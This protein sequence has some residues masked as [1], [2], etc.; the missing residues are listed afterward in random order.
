MI[1]LRSQTS[2]YE[3]AEITCFLLQKGKDKTAYINVFTAIELVPFE[4][5]AS[6]LVGSGPH[7]LNQRYTC[8]E[9]TLYLVRVIGLKVEE[10]VSIFESAEHGF[11]LERGYLKAKVI[12]AHLVRQEPSGN[13][14]LMIERWQKESLSAILPARP[15][16]FRVWTKIQLQKS[17]STP[18]QINSGA[19]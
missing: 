8:D 15:T 13:T 3:S 4:Q 16:G 1:S 9:G 14:P 6:P 19:I 2:E 11:S 12:N 17:G 10:A 18:V 7:S 5:P